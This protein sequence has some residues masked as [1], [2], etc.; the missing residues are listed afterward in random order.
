MIRVPVIETPRLILRG[1]RPADLAALTRF[2]R[3]PRSHI[4]GGPKGRVRSA[5]VLLGMAAHWLRRG[6]GY[7]QIVV[8]ATG[9][10]AGAVGLARFPGADEPELGAF[11]Y[12]GH[13]GQGIALEAA[14]AARAHAA[15]AFGIDRVASFVNPANARAVAFMGRLGATFE[16]EGR[17]AGHACHIYRHPQVGGSPA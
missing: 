13:E 4:I 11:L 5:L 9:A 7:W 14:R 15:R 10:R 2:F 12:D 3:S 1:P 17:V 8:R 16:R 6:Y